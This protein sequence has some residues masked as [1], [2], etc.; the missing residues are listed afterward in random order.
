MQYNGV[1]CKGRHL[2]AKQDKAM[3]LPTEAFRVNIFSSLWHTVLLA[4]GKRP[5][6]KILVSTSQSAYKNP[7]IIL[8]SGSP[9]KVI[10]LESGFLIL[11]AFLKTRC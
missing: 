7:G 10:I 2:V 3:R 4:K 11:Q 5:L 9:E 8:R 1:G 6:F